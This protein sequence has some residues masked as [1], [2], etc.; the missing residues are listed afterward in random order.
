M[1]QVQ[2]WK[3]GKTFNSILLCRPILHYLLDIDIYKQKEQNQVKNQIYVSISG[4]HNHN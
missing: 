1:L 3:N 2:L 4:I